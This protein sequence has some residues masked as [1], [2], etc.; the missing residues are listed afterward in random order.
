MSDPQF[1]EIAIKGE[2]EIAKMQPGD[3]LLVKVDRALTLTEHAWIKRNFD[4][5]LPGGISTMIADQGFDFS[6]LRPAPAEPTITKKRHKPASGFWPSFLT[7]RPISHTEAREIAAR[8]IHSMFRRDDADHARASIPA[9]PDRDDD[10]LINAYIQQQEARDGVVAVDRDRDDGNF[11]P[12][13]PDPLPAGSPPPP[14]S[15]ND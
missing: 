15:S 12:T 11:R 6:I 8:L 13:A 4:V 5:H 2:A 14:P 1:I 7:K 3:I 10:L 9:N